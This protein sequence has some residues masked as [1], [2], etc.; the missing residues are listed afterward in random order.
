MQNRLWE[1]QKGNKNVITEIITR[2]IIFLG[3]G[4]MDNKEE[5]P[6]PIE[7]QNIKVDTVDEDIP[8]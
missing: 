7:K 6:T 3:K 8:F 5:L 2:Q 1:D 4:D